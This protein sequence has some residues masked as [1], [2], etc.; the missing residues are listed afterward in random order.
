M[1]ESKRTMTGCRKEK[2]VK[3]SREEES[4]K[5]SQEEV[6]DYIGPRIRELCEKKH[7]TKYRLSKRSGVS[8]I[9]ISRYIEGRKVPAVS[10][11]EK[12]CRGFDISLSQF[13]EE[14]GMRKI[15][16]LTDEQNTLIEIMDQLDEDGQ[17]N[18]IAYGT[19]LV[20]RKEDGNAF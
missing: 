4:A 13:F 17:K 5:I 11:I 19:F 9:N 15:P 7:M 10:T 16:D 20:K 1:G 2:S 18:L 12:L 3:V 8:L 6:I 14:K